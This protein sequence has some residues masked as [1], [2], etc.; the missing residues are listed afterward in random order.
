[1]FPIAQHFLWA[2]ITIFLSSHH[3]PVDSLVHNVILELRPGVDLYEVRLEVVLA[4]NQDVEAQDL[5]GVV[6]RLAH[7]VELIPYLG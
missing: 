6:H 3:W 2:N 7:T 5:V 1:M 4:L